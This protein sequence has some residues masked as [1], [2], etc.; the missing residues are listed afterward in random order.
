MYFCWVKW[1]WCDH[2]TDKF[3]SR[4]N[5]ALL[6][7]RSIEKTDWLIRRCG[8]NHSSF[9]RTPDTRHRRGII[10]NHSSFNT[11]TE[12]TRWFIW[13]II[14]CLMI[15]SFRACTDDSLKIFCFFP[16]T[17]F[18]LLNRIRVIL[19]QELTAID[20]RRISD[21]TDLTLTYIFPSMY[22]CII[23]NTLRNVFL[24]SSMDDT[25]IECCMSDRTWTLSDFIET[26][27]AIIYEWISVDLR[28]PNDDRFP[29]ENLLHIRFS[30]M[31]KLFPVNLWIIHVRMKDIGNILTPQKAFRNLWDSL[32][33]KLFSIFWVCLTVYDRL[34]R[35]Y[36]LEAWGRRSQSFHFI[37]DLWRKSILLPKSI[38][39]SLFFT[40]F[41]QNR[42]EMV[43]NSKFLILS[44]YPLVELS[45]RLIVGI[46]R[47]QLC[48]VIRFILSFSNQFG[49]FCFRI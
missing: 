11:H 7:N 21:F 47:I 37:I 33:D 15:H 24:S 27:I 28:I 18:S 17:E 46:D 3:I 1:P 5:T 30:D 36:W 26:N 48:E 14:P 25:V 41:I 29:D 9:D 45:H 38:I 23:D 31:R 40:F 39:F 44:R 8:T 22:D 32:R 43:D 49:S 34:F 20:R 2:F 16:I 10:H 42:K 12:N 6:S 19:I 13:S 4:E 35:E